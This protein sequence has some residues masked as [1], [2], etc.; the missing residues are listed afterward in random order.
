MKQANIYGWDGYRW[1][2]GDIT[3]GFVPQLGGRI[4]SLKYRGEE[5][6]FVQDERRGEVFNFD[7]LIGD[8]KE[9]GFHFWGGNKTWVSPERLWVD[10]I[11]PLDLDAGKY[12]FSF[13]HNKVTMQSAICRETGL[14]ITRDIKI[15]SDSEVILTETI[16]NESLTPLRRGIWSVTQLL[17]PFDIYLPTAMENVRLYDDEDFKN[18]PI[19]KYMSKHDESTR[20]SCFDDGHFKFGARL[21]QGKVR[22]LRQM[23]NA[24]LEFDK[25]FSV[26][27]NAEYGHGS[28]VEIYNS[29]YYNYCEIEVHSPLVILNPGQSFSQEQE[30]RLKLFLL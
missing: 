15:G 20:I 26:D 14:C 19:A 25:T 22:A 27:S 7:Q 11:P 23:K 29:P 2:L 16:K 9:F 17:R 5:I 24:I 4:M 1:D 18:C 6:F 21:E 13:D 3:L 8:K 30:W 28:C 12:E 10:K